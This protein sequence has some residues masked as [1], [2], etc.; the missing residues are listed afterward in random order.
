MVAESFG[1][2]IDHKLWYTGNSLRTEIDPKSGIWKASKKTIVN[3]TSILI[4]NKRL[5]A[6]NSL[7]DLLKEVSSFKKYQS[8]SGNMKYEAEI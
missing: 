4:D 2:M 7:D 3:N 8:A 1:T 6:W 5:H